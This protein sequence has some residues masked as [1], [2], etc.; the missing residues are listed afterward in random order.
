MLIKNVKIKVKKVN[1]ENREFLGKDGQTKVKRL[2]VNIAFL[3]GDGDMCK[4]TSFDP[5]WEI[6]KEGSDWVLPTVKRMECFD[7]MIQN[8]MV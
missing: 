1:A 5:S 2:V 8:V 4:L 7:G 3:D 6:P